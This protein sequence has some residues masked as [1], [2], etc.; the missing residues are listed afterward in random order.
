MARRDWASRKSAQEW[1]LK[2]LSEEK[3]GATENMLNTRHD[4]NIV[5]QILN[6][7]VERSVVNLYIDS[8]KVGIES[9]I[10]KLVK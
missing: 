10:Y 4:P 3:N 1:I 7:L 2:I 6:M 9:R 5:A 8:N